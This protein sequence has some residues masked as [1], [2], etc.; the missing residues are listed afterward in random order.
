[1]ISYRIPT[2]DGNRIVTHL[3]PD[4]TGK[5]CE[6]RTESG[7]SDS[8]YFPV[9]GWAVVVRVREGELPRVTFEPVVEDEFNGHVVL[10]DLEE[11][12]GPLTL[13]DIS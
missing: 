6:V 11:E 10:G 12:V 2:E 5:T 4:T 3:I 9:V 8:E 13:V 1:M 7:A